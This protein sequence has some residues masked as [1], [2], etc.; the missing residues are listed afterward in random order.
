[1]N[2]ILYLI[3]RFYLCLIKFIRHWYLNSSK[4]YSHFII[5]LLEKFD[6]KLAFKITAR[7]LFNPLYQDRSFI[8]YILGFFF[9]SARLIWGGFVYIIIIIIAVIIYLFWLIIPLFII[10]KIVFL[11]FFENKI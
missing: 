5:S 10:Y 7:H 4:I 1:M 11:A 2:L 8:G 9:R 6:K 3:K